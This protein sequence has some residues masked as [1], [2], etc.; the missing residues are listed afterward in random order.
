MHICV[1]AMT[2]IAGVIFGS[3]PLTEDLLRLP[4]HLT[5]LIILAIPYLVDVSPSAASV[6]TIAEGLSPHP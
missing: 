5:R 3:R 4:V 1:S 6:S 2:L